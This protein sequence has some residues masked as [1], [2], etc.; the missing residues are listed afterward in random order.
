MLVTVRDA[1]LAMMIQTV[2]IRQLGVQQSQGQMVEPG[3]L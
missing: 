3:C 2:D 1:L